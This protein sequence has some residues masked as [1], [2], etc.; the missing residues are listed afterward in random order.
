MVPFNISPATEADVPVIL[1]MIREL[2]EF[3]NLLHEVTVTETSLRDA[4]FG[5]ESVAKA[6]LA[7][8]LDGAVAGYALYYRTFSTFAGRPGI[9]LDDLYVRPGYRRL[10]LGTALLIRVAKI[11]SEQDGRFE[12]IALGWNEN[13]LRLYRSLGARVMKDWVLLRMQPGQCRKLVNVFDDARS[14]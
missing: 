12:W 6:L 10:G 9:F 11:A 2:A 4:L 14:L 3:E 13:A 8:D 5:P 7:R 1:E